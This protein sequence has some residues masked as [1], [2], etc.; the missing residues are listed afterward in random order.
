MV[1][2]SADPQLETSA[3][4]PSPDGGAVAGLDID[5]ALTEIAADVASVWEETAVEDELVH[6]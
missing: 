4:A 6:I 1:A 3:R 2:A 5:A